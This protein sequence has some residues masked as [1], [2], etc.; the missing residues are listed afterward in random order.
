MSF[1]IRFHHWSQD[2]W[3][4]AGAAWQSALTLRGCVPT[5]KRRVKLADALDHPLCSMILPT[6]EIQANAMCSSQTPYFCFCLKGGP[7][8]HLTILAAHGPP[9][10][11]DLCP[12]GALPKTSTA[13][14][15]SFSGLWSQIFRV[16]ILTPSRV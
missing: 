9:P 13:R 11:V 16:G 10:P 3:G 7:Q 2:L 14:E 5:C 15:A 1:Q 6:S 4:E 8:V 12:P